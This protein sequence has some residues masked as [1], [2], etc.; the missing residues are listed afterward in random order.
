MPIKWK[1]KF[2]PSPVIDRIASVRTYSEDGKAS[3]SG[4][5]VDECMPTLHSML[6]FPS[7][8]AE[9]DHETLVWRAL[10]RA[11]KTLTPETFLK[12]AN[13]EL[14]ARLATKV[15]QYSLLTS[16]SLS[17][18][19]FLRSINI[20]DCRI[21]FLDGDFPKKFI[22]HRNS[23]IKEFKT[24]MGETP[25]NYCKVVATVRAKSPSA[26]FHKAMR[27]I[28]L[29]RSLM[30]LM[31][32]PRMQIS[33]GLLSHEA[34][35]TVRLGGHHTVHLADGKSA[36]DGYWY[37]PY[38]KPKAIH[39]PDKPELISRNIRWAT[40]KIGDSSFKNQI[41][42]SLLM[43]VRGLDLH[44]HNAAFLKV[45]GALEMLTTPN[46]ADY[47]K[48]IRRSVF[49]FKEV[50][51]HR[52]VLEHLRLYRN[53][54]VHAGEES[55]NSRIHCFQLQTFYAAAAWFCIR[56]GSNF[57][58]LDELGTF[59]DLPLEPSVL[60]DRL[61]KIKKAIKFRAPR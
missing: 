42:S 56:N 22:S 7:V 47:E 28:D 43:Y 14:T 36:H 40:K 55:E 17:P 57:Q 54:N 12:A 45:W 60:E 4:F 26:A 8:V 35:N 27:A 41:V 18:K 52:Q 50:D 10:N 46:I 9:I 61:K 51:Y 48:L 16:I 23:L 38:Y 33:F 2:K 6:S 11:G 58:S 3:Y 31:L 19:K 21:Q 29:L 20:N 32:N 25:S 39:T 24:E 15:V 44:D 53:A 49:L 5:V 37:E 59:L 13:D 1:D 30:C 34:I